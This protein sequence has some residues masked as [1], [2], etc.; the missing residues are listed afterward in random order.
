MKTLLTSL[1][2]L[3]TTFV[4]AQ[5]GKP[6]SELTPKNDKAP[7]KSQISGWGDVGAYV[8]ETERNK[9]NKN[10]SKQPAKVNNLGGEDDPFGKTKKK[11]TNNLGEDDD[12]FGRKNKKITESLSDGDDPFGKKKKKTTEKYGD[13]EDPFGKT[14][15]SKPAKGKNSYANQEVSY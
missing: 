10:Q 12:P 11:P 2:L 13:D 8:G 3:C 5:N 1:L 6:K 9:A 7:T 15:K 4:F 14:K